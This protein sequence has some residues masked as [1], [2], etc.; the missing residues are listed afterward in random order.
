LRRLRK[1]AL[2]AAAIAVAVVTLFP[3]FW[4]VC[5]AFKPATEIYSL[6]RGVMPMPTGCLPRDQAGELRGPYGVGTPL[7]F[8][9]G[10]PSTAAANR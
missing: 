1:T 6:T 4:M 10:L 9:V 3:I 7:M 8:T 5:T 2:N